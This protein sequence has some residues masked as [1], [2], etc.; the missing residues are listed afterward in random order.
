MGEKM[1]SNIYGNVDQFEW[2]T[3]STYPEDLQKVVHWKTLIGGESPSIA[4]KDVLMG[5]LDLEAGGFYP[6][7]SHPAPEIYYIMSGTAE[8]TV[9]EETFI[10]VP[11]TAVY[12]SPNVPHRMVNHGYE[13]LRTVWFWWAPK[14]ERDVLQEGVEL[15][16]SMP[17]K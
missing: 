16:E 1:A 3:A 12:H 13:P 17:E 10:V 2:K 4:Q 14:G 6:L 15:L 5:V 8:W 11:G 9:G 7:H